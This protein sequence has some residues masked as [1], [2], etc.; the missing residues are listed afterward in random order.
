MQIMIIIAILTIT[1]SIAIYEIIKNF[2]NPKSHCDGCDE[3]DCPIK[4]I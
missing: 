3:K 1:I 2:K 4:N